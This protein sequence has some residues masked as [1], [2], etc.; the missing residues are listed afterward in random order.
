LDT[1]HDFALKSCANIGKNIH[2]CK[3]NNEKFNFCPR[4]GEDDGNDDGN[5]DDN[6]DDN[7]NDNDNKNARSAFQ[8]D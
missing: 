2:N 6:D 8:Q 4:I 3:K 1:I 7:V 5:D